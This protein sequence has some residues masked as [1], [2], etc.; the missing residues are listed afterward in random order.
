MKDKKKKHIAELYKI[1]IKCPREAN[2]RA[3]NK[4]VAAG[5]SRK[6]VAVTGF[7]LVEAPLF[8][9]VKPSWN[10]IPRMDAVA[11]VSV[12]IEHKDPKSAVEERVYWGS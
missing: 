12:V 5:I 8:G 4:L 3:I 1:Y 6:E 10:Q 7:L 9:M 11:D 2:Y